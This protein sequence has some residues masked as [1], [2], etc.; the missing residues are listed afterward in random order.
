MAQIFAEL[1]K[2]V[3]EVNIVFPERI[4]RVENQITAHQISW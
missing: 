2:R 3:F 1:V 4:V